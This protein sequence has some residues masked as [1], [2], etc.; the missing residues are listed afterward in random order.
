[1]SWLMLS[2]EH[3]SVHVLEAFLFVS[4]QF[5]AIILFSDFF[6]RDNDGSQFVYFIMF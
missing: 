3:I 5:L 1:M 2:S 4:Q 6:W